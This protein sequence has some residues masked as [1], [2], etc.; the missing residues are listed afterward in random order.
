MNMFFFDNILKLNE[1]N[2]NICEGKVT[3]EECFKVLEEMKSN[4][5]PGNDGF[6]VEFYQTFW[7]ILGD[8][9]VGSM[10]EAYDMGELSISQKQGVITLLEKEGKDS[11]YIQ[12]YRP[13]TLLNV[14]Y[15]ISKVLAKRIKEVLGNIIHHDQVGYIKHRNIGEAV[16]L[17]D[18]MFFNSLKQNNGY[19]LAVD[20]EKAFDSV[21]HEFLFEVLEL[22]GFGVSFCSWVKILYK[23]IS[24]CIMNGGNS[25]GYFDIKRGVRQG[26]PLS[27]YL[28]LLAI[29]ILAHTVRKDKVIKGFCFGNYEV[30]QILYADD[31][32]LFVKDARS[33]DRLKYIFG[34]F[35]EVSGLKVNKG[36]TN[37]VRMGGDDEL[38]DE[39]LFGKV[40]QEIKILGVYFSLDRKKRDDMNYKEILSK[41]KK[42]LGWWKQRDL[43]LMGKVHLLK[44]YAL[45]KLNYVSALIVV[46]NWV[47]AEVERI[48][49]EFL[50][51]GKDRIKRKIMN[52][53]YEDGGVKM[54]NYVL[55]V[56]TQRIMWVKR[57]LYGE[58]E[59]G[60]KMFFDY[61]CRSVGGRFIFLCDFEF[62]KLKLDIPPFY[63]ECLKAWQDIDK[64]RHFE[65]KH[66]NPI[67]FN[68]RQICIGGN[69]IFDLNLYEKGFFLIY[70][71][72]DKGHLRSVEYFQNLGM[73][74]DDLLW[75]HDIFKVIPGIVKDITKLAEVQQVD[76][77]NYNMV[78]NICSQKINFE[79]MKSRRMYEY[80]IKDLQ[81]SYRLQI[82]DG[83]RNFDYS[84]K[85]LKQIF[86]RLRSTTLIMKQREF[87]FKLLH[88][89][90]YTKE[91]LMK[92]GFVQNNLCSFCQQEIETYAHLFLSCQKVKEMWQGI[93]QN[94]DLIEISNMDWKDIFVG[95]LGNSIRIKCVNTLI[96]IVKY[97]L[98][99]SRSEGVIPSLA[100]IKKAIL[101]CRKEEKKLAVKRGKLGVHLLKWEEIN[102]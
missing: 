65:N 20:F 67:I 52:Q 74:S 41:I 78:L 89:A 11:M 76:I 4:K 3:K 92:F 93:I 98:F 34:E 14:D 62:S 38:P 85:E 35:E 80:L 51:K 59:I 70:H 90:I 10:N 1:E 7:P 86:G 24:S 27:P 26:D 15:K 18:D 33:V 57:L 84:D 12:N 97:L 71:M 94:L 99:K 37:F 48:A 79:G 44:T 49:F 82:T 30:R 2:Q 77:L 43:T 61:G 73:E 88:C 68:N 69:M 8:I 42:L 19:L 16:R 102:I 91:K 39:S 31:F 87:Q 32:T 9:L 5:A 75:I 29:E 72:L 23:D 45:S 63:L 40:V 83:E 36:K 21:S 56:K 81:N 66:I 28:F 6:T 58:K 101:E 50:W 47:Y 100:K 54:F 96:I 22:F 53:D 25:T 17:I 60:W 95:L 64:C 13:I 55:F 46:P